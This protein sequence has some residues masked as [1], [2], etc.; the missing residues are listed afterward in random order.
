MK[1]IIYA[2]TAAR[3]MVRH[4]KRAK[5]I[6][7]KIVQYAENL[8]AQARNIKPLVGVDASR[9]R[10]QDFR[11]LFRETADTITILDIG[12]RGGIYD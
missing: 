6:K 1:A 2:A 4:P 8:A 7:A 9:L 12:P 3:A 5:L 11:V 10:V